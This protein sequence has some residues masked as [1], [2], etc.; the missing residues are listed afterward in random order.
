MWSTVSVVLLVGE[1]PSASVALARRVCQSEVAAMNLE[2]FIVRMH[3]ETVEKFQ[4]RATWDHI[5][6]SDR[7]VL[8]NAIAGLPNTL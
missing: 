2:N 7:E 1:S 4:Q 3:L 6:D 5:L 8:N